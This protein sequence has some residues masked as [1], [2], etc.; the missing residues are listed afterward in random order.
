MSCARPR[1]V[2]PYLSRMLD[3]VRQIQE[4]SMEPKVRCQLSVK[5][6]GEMPALPRG[7]CRP[8]VK[9]RKHDNVR[10]GLYNAWRANEDAGEW[11]GSKCRDSER[12]FEAVD[13]PAKGVPF[14]HDIHDT[15][16]RLVATDVSG[17]HNHAGTGSIDGLTAVGKV[18]DRVQEI[19]LDQQLT[20]RRA[21]ASGNHEPAQLIEVL[22]QRDA[23]D[24][25]AQFAEHRLVFGKCSLERKHADGSHDQAP[26]TAIS[27]CCGIVPI[28]IP[29]IGVPMP[30]ETSAMILASW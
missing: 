25:S 7:H 11:L 12:N 13:L 17:H 15:Q 10:S 18:P 23:T 26:R 16:S 1:A 21:F 19:P 20:N 27:S 29:R 3:A 4:V 28:S 6:N 14:D 5:G 9:T 2:A 8:I 24:V 22:W 30:L